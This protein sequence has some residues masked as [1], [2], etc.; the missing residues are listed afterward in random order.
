MD[1]EDLIDNYAPRNQTD[2]EI[3]AMAEQLHTEKVAIIG[4]VSDVFAE[5]KR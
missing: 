1:C 2:P 5:L 4:T 3:P